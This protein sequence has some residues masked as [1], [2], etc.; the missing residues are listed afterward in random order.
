MEKREELETLRREQDELLQQERTRRE[1]LEEHQ[2]E[3][4]RKLQQAADTL[5]QLEDQRRAAEQE[6][7]VRQIYKRNTWKLGIWQQKYALI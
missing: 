4:A 3:Q 1:G 6:L 7:S 2:S 5:K